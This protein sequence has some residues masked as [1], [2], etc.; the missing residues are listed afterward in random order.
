MLDAQKTAE[1]SSGYIFMIEGWRELLYPLGY[2]SSLAFG[3]RFLLQW[4]ASER[5]QKSVVTRS[6]WQISLLGNVLL[7]VHSLIQ[8]QFHVCV[9]Q[10]CNSVI[11]WRNLNLMQASSQQVRT[12]GAI[13]LI[14][15]AAVFTFLIFYW[16]GAFLGEGTSHWFR[17]P[18][19]LKQ[20]SPELSIHPLWHFF[21]M[22][23]L[24]LFSSRFWV[25]WWC[26]EK[27]KT[28]YL[29]PAFWWLSLA[30]GALSL[31]YFFWIDDP[32]NMLGPAVGLIPYLRNLMLIGGVNTKAQRDT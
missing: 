15:S 29:G 16:Q 27:H 30:G 22:V 23:G 2:L 24:V 8:V 13:L 19:F 10:A 5:Q 1:I 31:C 32:V 18:T 17:L 4:L 28:S 9:V 25:Q 6:F 12:R 7:F 26:A 14:L 20:E 21:G 3:M 11:S